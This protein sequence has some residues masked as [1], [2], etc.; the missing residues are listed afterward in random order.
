MKLVNKATRAECLEEA[1]SWLEPVLMSL[2][3]TAEVCSC[4]QAKRF[5]NFEERQLAL[6]LEGVMQKLERAR[7]SLAKDKTEVEV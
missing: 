6:V 5:H 4:C 1:I 3:T 7:K 2:D